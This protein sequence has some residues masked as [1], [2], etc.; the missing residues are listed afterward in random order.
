[1]AASVYPRGRRASDAGRVANVL[2]GFVVMSGSQSGNRH[3]LASLASFF[4]HEIWVCSRLRHVTCQCSQ[5][6]F[7]S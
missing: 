2:C 5:R 1:M 4:L 6:R 3:C 7:F